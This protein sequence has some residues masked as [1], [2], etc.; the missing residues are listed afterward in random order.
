MEITYSLQAWKV[1]HDRDKKPWPQGMA[2]TEALLG[3]FTLNSDGDVEAVPNY[4]MQEHEA[5]MD[6]IER[7][8]NEGIMHEYLKTLKNMMS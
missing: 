6:Q 3:P 5:L 1:I 7:E 4:S 2:A 8:M